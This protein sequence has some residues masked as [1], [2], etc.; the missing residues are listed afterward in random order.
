M[1]A[2]VERLLAVL[3]NWRSA[4]MTGRALEA[5]AAALDGLDAE[6]VVVDNDSGDGSE[7]ALRARVAGRDWPV[8]VRVV[9]SGRNGGYGA[10]NNVGIRAGRAD[11]QRPDAVYLLNSD[12]FPEPE[13]LRVL[14]DHLNAHPDVGM[15]GSQ[16]YS[17]DDPCHATAFRFPGLASEF[18]QCARTGPI[19]RLL[20]RYRVPLSDLSRPR[21]PDWFAGASALFRQEVL[22]EVG[23]FDEGFFLYFEETELFHRAARA[24]W[25]AAFLP[26]SRVEHIGSVSTG[27]KTWRAVP[28]YWFDSRWRYFERCH[29]RGYAALAT[30]ARLAG[31]LVWKTRRIFGAPRLDPPGTFRRTLRHG[32]GRMLR[33]APGASPPPVVPSRCRSES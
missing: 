19:S 31:L 17:D 10:G 3:L 14:V 23:L 13:A 25:Q 24:G 8:P 6:I 1:S 30:L 28:D 11:G 9:Q 4:E 2:R 32:L 26:A 21:R 16:L 20:W 5:L 29:G 33:G 12:A 15:A 7:E 27:M 22:E 18:E